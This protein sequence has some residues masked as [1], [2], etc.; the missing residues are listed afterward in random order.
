[1]SDFLPFVL[2]GL[3]AGS[4][5]GLAGT[6]LVLTYKTSG[7]F[8]FA[9][10]TIA[11]LIAYAFYDLREQQHLPWPLAIVICVLVLSPLAA[12]ALEWIARRLSDAPVAMKVVAT[13]GLLVAI[14]QLLVIRYGPSTCSA[15]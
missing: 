9:H 4:V 6:G 10:G 11:A 8:N 2:V 3:T 1:M 14:Q 15:V 13:V 12:L 7:I 5:Y